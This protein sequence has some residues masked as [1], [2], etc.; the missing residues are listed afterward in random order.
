MDFNYMPHHE[1]ETER[2]FD[3]EKW[4]KEIEE[5]EK[6]GYEN[7]A[8]DE[9]R[10]SAKEKRKH[11]KQKMEAFRLLLLLAF[12]TVAACGVYTL[13]SGHGKLVDDGWFWGWLV[14]L[15]ACILKACIGEKKSSEDTQENMGVFQTFLSGIKE[16]WKS[17]RINE[18][19]F[20]LSV[21]C[22]GCVIGGA[23][24]KFEVV[25]R[26]VSGAEA[27]G[28]AWISYESHKIEVNN[29][30]EVDGESAQMNDSTEVKPS[31][32]PN[33]SDR[34]D[35][36]S[37]IEDFIEKSDYDVDDLRQ[38]EISDI[39]LNH[40]VDLSSEDYEFIFFTGEGYVIEDWE[41]QEEIDDAVLEMIKDLRREKKVN[42]FD[43]GIAPQDVQNEINYASEDEKKAKSFMEIERIQQVRVDV[44]RDY[45]K[46][47]IANLVG[48]SE[49]LKALV[50][51]YYRG[52]QQS[53]LYHY[54]KSILWESEYLKYEDVSN[55]VASKRLSKIAQRY[56]DIAF[57]CKD[58]PE[59]A[60]ATRLQ[61]AYEN[62]ANWYR[63][64]TDEED[65]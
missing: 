24:G 36:N 53:I 37:D 50:L 56:G 40:I 31:E 54:G 35:G 8:R 16:L 33:V 58:C 18:K 3:I 60:R 5:A 19:L 7:G 63:G 25:S 55:D 39:E 51:Y 38:I 15:A 57:V 41:D 47:S 21:V 12:I 22:L 45:P 46:K 48:N 61:T 42:L 23:I 59:S 62:A 20:A 4:E 49:Q 17:I 28:E 14:A 44:Y 6:R 13:I 27:F 65:R 32:E 1:Q 34:S 2:L 43:G 52:R 29:D 9:Q 30:G 26:T 11:N 64:V 10:R